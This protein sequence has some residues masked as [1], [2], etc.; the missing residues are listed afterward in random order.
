M[1]KLLNRKL[2]NLLFFYELYLNGIDE[3]NYLEWALLFNIRTKIEEEIRK[4]RNISNAYMRK[5]STL[6]NELKEKASFYSTKVL[7][8]R[9]R[10]MTF[11]KPPK[12]YWWYYL[13]KKE[14]ESREI[15]S[16]ASLHEREPSCNYA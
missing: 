14:Q 4:N 8:S 3:E 11:P 6:D 10:K 16:E 7:C 12:K 2:D 15:K 9:L 1:K 13:D 5:L